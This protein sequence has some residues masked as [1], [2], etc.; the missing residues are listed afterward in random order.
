VILQIEERF[1]IKIIN[2]LI[3]ANEVKHGGNQYKYLISKNE[4]TG[5]LHITKKTLNWTLYEKLKN[6]IDI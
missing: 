1:K 3:N 2:G 4:E 6:K 5:K